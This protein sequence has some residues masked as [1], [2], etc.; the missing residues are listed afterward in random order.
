MVPRAV[1]PA[2]VRVGRRMGELQ[3]RICP[4]LLRP[5]GSNA[6]ARSLRAGWA[7]AEVYQDALEP[8]VQRQQGHGDAWKH[9]S[10][11][12]AE[13]GVQQGLGDRTERTMPEKEM[14]AQYQGATIL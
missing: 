14:G 7:D 11:K 1:G 13:D 9:S 12:S 4:E 8:G 5:V 2:C 10:G 6:A 3:Q